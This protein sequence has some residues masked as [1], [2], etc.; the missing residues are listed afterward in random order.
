MFSEKLKDARKKMKLSQEEVAEIINTSRSN[1]SKYETGF[2]EPNLSTLKQ[3]CLLYRIS[4][5]YL[6][7][8]DVKQ[9]TNENNIS[10]N[11]GNNGTATVNINN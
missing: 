8:I 1:I 3:L 5:D 7:D 11:Q 9:I 4:A 6:L 2:L 10:I